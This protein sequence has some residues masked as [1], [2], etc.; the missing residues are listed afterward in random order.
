MLH[1]CGCRSKR[2][3]HDHTS[4]VEALLKHQEPTRTQGQVGS[5]QG[6]LAKCVWVV[7]VALLQEC[8]L[9]GM[10]ASE[11]HHV[12]LQASRALED[13]KVRRIYTQDLVH[14]SATSRAK[15]LRLR[16]LVAP[17]HNECK[18]DVRGQARG[19]RVVLTEV[20]TPLGI[21]RVLAQV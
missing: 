3:P 16:L 21:S 5:A 20:R 2:L 18:A 10:K 19:A 13:P 8:Y 7:C 11:S 1:T 15:L 9:D 6:V 17:Q 14:T 4:L 12:G